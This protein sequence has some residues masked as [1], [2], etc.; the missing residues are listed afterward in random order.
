MAEV[1]GVVLVDVVAGRDI[2][3]VV[4]RRENVV[5]TTVN[6]AP[7]IRRQRQLMLVIVI[8]AV[9]L[10]KVVNILGHFWRGMAV[11][12]DQA[13]LRHQVREGVLGFDRWRV[14]AVI[15][16]VGAGAVGGGVTSAA[17]VL[18]VP[19]ICRVRARSITTRA[20]LLAIIV[21]W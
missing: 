2:L 14:S 10:A 3:T 5:N 1:E 4:I 16:G 11:R 19:T 21:L 20:T 15:V 8:C 18:G 9:D 6:L 7:K 13:V 17:L 12:N